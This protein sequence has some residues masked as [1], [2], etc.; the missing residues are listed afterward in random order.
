MVLGKILIG[1]T[2]FTNAEILAYIAVIL[3]AV[4][5]IT[6]IILLIAMSVQ[7]KSVGTVSCV[8][9]IIQAQL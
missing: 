2:T 5:G 6:A 1:G 8:L 4:L 9:L 3:F 7:S